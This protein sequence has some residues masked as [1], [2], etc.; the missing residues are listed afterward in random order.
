MRAIITFFVST[1]LSLVLITLLAGE[2]SYGQ[3]TSDGLIAYYPFNGNADD[4]SGNG[5]NGIPQNLTFSDGIKNIAAHFT[6]ESYIVVP[7]YNSLDFSTAT[8]LTFMTWIKQ[9]QPSPDGK[10]GEILRKMGNGYTE[11]DE[12]A[13][14]ISPYYSVCGAFNSPQQTYTVIESNSRIDLNTWNHL[15]LMWN[16]ADRYLSVYINGILDKRVLS[17]VASIQNTNIELRIGHAYQYYLHSFSGLLDELKIYNRA[18]SGEEIL[19]IYNSYL[20]GQISGRVSSDGYGL[21]GILVKVLDELGNVIEG[22]EEIF[23][24]EEGYYDIRN[25]PVGNYQVMIVEPLGY[26]SDQ[27]PKYCIVKANENCNLDFEL[28]KIVTL[29]MARSKGYWKHQFDVYVNRKGTAQELESDLLHFVELVKQ[30]YDLHYNIF[31]PFN[32]LD[33]WQ[34]VISL[35]SNQQM[36]ERAIQELGVLIMNMVSNKIGQYTIVTEDNRDV[37]D[38][39]QYVSELILD[40]VLENDELGKILAESVNNQQKISSGV[41]PEGNILFKS[42]PQSY[43]KNYYK[44]FE[45]YP[46]PFNPLTSIRFTIPQNVFVNIKVY[47]IIGNEIAT[48]VDE[49]KTEGIHAVS[50]DASNLPSGV[51]VYKMKAGEFVE[52]R[53]MILLK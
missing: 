38:V 30:H 50:F 43:R 23:T 40:G 34:K 18:F 26:I 8:G 9:E 6:S 45:N 7:D 20:S 21:K 53:K 39:I 36:R 48:L 31:L 3:V 52:T 25:I 28:S 14:W 4:M 47:D 1:I 35:K 33:D 5:N 13:F 22:Y 41:V 12:Y 42:R 17:S 24:D 46:N 32:S 15:V 19:S 2:L 10:S 16:S 37:G 51:Y 11:D 27:N 44:L 29:N 49:F